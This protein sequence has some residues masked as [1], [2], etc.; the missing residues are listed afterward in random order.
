M[1]V[2]PQFLLALAAMAAASFF[3]RAGGFFLMRFVTVTPRLEAAI[4]AIPPAVM[5]GIIAPTIARGQ[6]AELLGVASVV[7]IMKATGND[8]LAALVGVTAVALARTA[9]F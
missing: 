5:I 3:C 8:L 2:S 1:N 4:S 6:P 7:L 9:G